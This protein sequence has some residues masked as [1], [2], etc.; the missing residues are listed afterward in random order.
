MGRCPLK[1]KYMKTQIDYT[2]I[3]V[4][5][6]K[7]IQK[8]NLVSHSRFFDRYKLDSAKTNFNGKVLYGNNIDIYHH[9]ETLYLSCSFP[10]LVHGH[11]FTDFPPSEAREV[12]LY[13]SQLIGVDLMKGDVV[14]FEVGI[15]SK[16]MTSF[17]GMC[18][19]ISGVDGWNF[20]KKIH[21]VFST[22][23]TIFN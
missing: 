14:A 17:K 23:K 15:I 5:G 3:K 1:I 8:E 18:N 16:C 4:T 2:K 20:R 13:L 6:V 9:N 7:E 19:K 21:A 10:Y 11:N 12:L 22:A